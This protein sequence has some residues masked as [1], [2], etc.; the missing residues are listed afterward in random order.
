MKFYKLGDAMN[1]RKG[2]HIF[3]VVFLLL[4]TLSIYPQIDKPIDRIIGD[5]ETVDLTADEEKERDLIFGS[6]DVEDEKI[7]KGCYPLCDEGMTEQ[8]EA[9]IRASFF[10]MKGDPDVKIFRFKP[11]DRLT[12]LEVGTY[13][14]FM[15]AGGPTDVEAEEMTHDK[16]ILNGSMLMRHIEY[17]HLMRV[18]GDMRKLAE[19][20]YYNSGKAFE[21]SPCVNQKKV[22]FLN[23]VT[24]ELMKNDETTRKGL[25]ESA[26]GGLLNPDPR[27]RLVSA[28]IL[29]RL[30]PEPYHWQYI[31]E[32]IKE[33]E[34][35]LNPND[36]ELNIDASYESV[37]YQKYNYSKLTKEEA[38]RIIYFELL[39]LR[40]FISR[41][42][43]VRQI[44]NC[45]RGAIRA[46]PI[47]V[48][49]LLEKPIEDEAWC[50]IP[51][52]YFK[53]SAEIAAIKAGL[54]N[55]D[56]YIRQACANA[57][58][59][60]L[61]TRNIKQRVKRRILVTLLKSEFSNKVA[62]GWTEGEV[63]TLTNDEM[64]RMIRAYVKKNGLINQCPE[65]ADDQYDSPKN[66]CDYE[67]EG[68]PPGSHVDKP[69]YKSD[70]EFGDGIGT[71]VKKSTDDEGQPF[72]KDYIYE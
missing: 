45:E 33:Q 64:D 5:T 19:D 14:T 30:I 52:N 53:S 4:S 24:I 38:D 37:K 28:D 3:L 43:L 48:F 16:E 71:F 40:R 22:R 36:P 54:K 59:R 2:L 49:R 65:D 61:R 41:M 50:R 44:R 25:I 70:L 6:E 34:K 8:Q 68:N 58:V 27:V 55:K 26:L 39:K 18:I 57:L 1:R 20:K 35:Y 60:I 11:A 13:L 42:I 32:R 47:E 46:I 17:P 69:I 66:P 63:D 72:E 21:P 23:P 9:E 62:V 67:P 10:I 51:M 7:D 12:G 56:P 31:N 29:R 15:R